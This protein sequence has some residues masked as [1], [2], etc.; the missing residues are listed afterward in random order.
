MTFPWKPGHDPIGYQE[1]WGF[2]LNLWEQAAPRESIS[3]DSLLPS[4]GAGG[5]VVIDVVRRR[6][7]ITLPA[8]V[9]VTASST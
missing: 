8:N 2:V 4:D 3:W 6:L 7:V 5:W 1:K 9:S